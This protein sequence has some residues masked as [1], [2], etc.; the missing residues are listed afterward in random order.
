M[1]GRVEGHGRGSRKT[2]P[3]EPY[4]LEMPLTDSAHAIRLARF[5]AACRHRFLPRGEETT[6]EVTR[7]RTVLVIVRIDTDRLHD[8][9]SLPRPLRRAQTCA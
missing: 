6:G 8:V 7:C 3:D 5:L 2:A 9:F 1:P 4:R